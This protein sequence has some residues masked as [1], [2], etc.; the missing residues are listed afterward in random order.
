MVGKTPDQ[1]D[2][3]CM[4]CGIVY[5]KQDEYEYIFQ[6]DRSNTLSLTPQRL[7]GG[8][9]SRLTSSDCRGY[10]SCPEYLPIRTK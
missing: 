6:V 8:F 1:F 3:C 9:W 10:R 5:F 2:L 7:T 4:L